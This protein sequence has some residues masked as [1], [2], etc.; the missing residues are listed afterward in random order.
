MERDPSRQLAWLASELAAAEKAG[1]RVWLM[2]KHI[3]LYLVR[4][5]PSV[6]EVE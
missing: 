6:K 2:G 1:E 5:F 4:I 3:S